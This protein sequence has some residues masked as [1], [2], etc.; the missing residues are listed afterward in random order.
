MAGIVLAKMADEGIF[1]Y[2]HQSLVLM[3]VDLCKLLVDSRSVFRGPEQDWI[4]IAVEYAC[5]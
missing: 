1:F 3:H 5:W 2:Y 4:R